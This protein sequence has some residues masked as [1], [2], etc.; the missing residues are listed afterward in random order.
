MDVLV[1]RASLFSWVGPDFPK[2]LAFY[3]ADG[4]VWLG[5]IAREDDAVFENISHTK[6]EPMLLV[7]GLHVRER[8]AGGMK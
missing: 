5:S 4:S 3:N 6:R 2:D 1:E 8:R 7:P